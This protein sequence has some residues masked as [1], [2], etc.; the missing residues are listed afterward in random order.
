MRSSLYQQCQAVKAQ[1]PDAIVF[2]RL[3]DFYEAFDEDAETAARELD[4]ALTSRLVAQGKRVPMASVPHHAVE[5]YVARLIEKGYRVAIAEQVDQ[6][7]AGQSETRLGELYRDWLSVTNGDESAYPSPERL[8]QYQEW[9]E[10]LVIGGSREA[11]G[12]DFRRFCRVRLAGQSRHLDLASAGQAFRGG[13]DFPA[14][15]GWECLREREPTK[16]TAQANPAVERCQDCRF[17]VGFS[18]GRRYPTTWRCAKW[19][20]DP[21]PW[22]RACHLAEPK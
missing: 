3:G 20:P 13:K 9:A 7:A 8:A 14:P 17:L 22:K 16:D 12:A 4:L 5:G 18:N 2:F 10:E 19:Q 11:D 6:A 15:A 21:S 1:H